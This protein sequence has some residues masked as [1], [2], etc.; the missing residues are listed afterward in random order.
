MLKWHT[1]INNGDIQYNTMYDDGNHNDGEA[2]DLIY[3]GAIS[4]IQVNTIIAYQISAEDNSN[5][6]SLMPCEPVIFELIE[7]ENPLLFINEFMA[8][9]DSTIADEAGEYDDWIEVYNGDDDPV[10]LGR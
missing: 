5:N 8:S 6:S 1:L 4:D 7:S 2:G 3:G 9:N 10:W